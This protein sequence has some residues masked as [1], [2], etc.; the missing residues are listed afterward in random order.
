MQ[1][2][3]YYLILLLVGLAGQSLAADTL[4]V[5][6][7]RHVNLVNHTNYDRVA[8]FPTEG[9]SFNKVYMLFTLGCATGGCSDWDYDVNNFIMKE[10]G[11]KDSTIRAYDTISEN[12]LIVDTL[13]NVFD[14]LERFELGRFITPYGTYMN[15][16][17]QQYGV[18]GYDSS[19]EHTFIYDVTD[20]QMLLKDS[21]TIRSQYN[22][23]SAGFSADIKF[24][25]IEGTPQRN[26]LGISNVYS[27]GGGYQNTEQFESQVIPER[28]IEIPE[29]TKQAQVK[30]II[31]GH[32][33]NQAEGCAEFCDKYYEYKVDGIARFKH[34]MWRDDCGEV[35]VAPQGGTWIFSRGNWCPGDKVYEQ[36]FEITP[37][38]SG[39]SVKLDMDIEPYVVSGSGG[40]SHNISST[41]FFYGEDNYDFDAE[42][43]TVISPST[44]SEHIPFNPSC[45]QVI[46]VIKN[47]SHKELTYAKIEYGPQNGQKKI[48]EW[49]G[50]LGFQ[51]KDTL[52]LESPA[53]S[54]VDA[55]Q[56]RFEV[57][58]FNQNHLLEDQVNYN[59]FYF[60]EVELVPRLEP[61]RVMFRTNGVPEENRF[62][63]TNHKGEI[64]HEWSDLDP[65]TVYQE[66]FNLPSGCYQLLLTDEGGDGLDFWYYGAINPPYSDGRN[67]YLRIFK[68][69]GGLYENFGGDFGSGVRYNFIVGQMDIEEQEVIEEDFTIIPNPNNGNF[70]LEIPTSEIGMAKVTVNNS[71]GQVV[72]TD[73]EV[74]V[75]ESY[76]Y[77]INLSHVEAGVYYVRLET[78]NQT[79]LEKVIIIK[80]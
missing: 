37:F 52:Y 26:V 48:A 39:N 51:Q 75:D 11:F 22:G 57:R 21:V 77:P 27:R 63:I 38:L 45:G 2:K 71:A 50:N 79:Y 29:G 53:W 62:T 36:R 70:S 46:L 73:E 35:A 78:E 34:R 31:T 15:F 13:W 40:S 64:V 24:V 16:R 44:F 42:V 32:G 61:F 7:H 23:W 47:N 80:E 25:M 76:W 12:P 43:E 59:D 30:V 1:F 66:T 6:A 3:K 20:Y 17:N 67:G 28:D 74:P 72:F 4:V 69:G 54:G 58:M 10:T 9:K 49:N 19:W 56:N 60:T 5:Q 55:N 68:D 14:E 18:A 33:A 65:F 41:V 8:F